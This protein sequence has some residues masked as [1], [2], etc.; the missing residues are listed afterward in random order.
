[1]LRSTAQRSS[2]LTR[3]VR[4][5]G[6]HKAVLPAGG[7]LPAGQAV[8]RRHRRDPLC[9]REGGGRRGGRVECGSA[10]RSAG[11]LQLARCRAS[12]AQGSKLRMAQPSFRPAAAPGSAAPAAPHGRCAAAAYGPQRCA[13]ERCPLPRAPRQAPPA[14]PPPPPL[15]PLPPRAAARPTRHGQPPCA[16]AAAPPPLQHQHSRDTAL[17][18]KAGG[19]GEKTIA[20]AGNREQRRG[21]GCRDAGARRAAGTAAAHSPCSA[22]ASRQS[23]CSWSITPGRRSRR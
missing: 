1:M 15:L 5:H 20:G 4:H 8:G 14:P 3:G 22:S 9:L 12:K 11:L 13:P 23:I 17:S 16:A 19:T 10:P 7:A 2:T 6:A 18:R 21:Q